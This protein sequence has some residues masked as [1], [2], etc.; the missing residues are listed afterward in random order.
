MSIILIFYPNVTITVWKQPIKVQAL[1]FLD[2][3]VWDMKGL[4]HKKAKI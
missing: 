3:T 2:Q 1:N 4:H